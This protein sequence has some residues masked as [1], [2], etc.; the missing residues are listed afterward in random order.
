M[1]ILA[2]EA[3][4]Q[5]AVR[6]V[7]GEK[8]TRPWGAWEV[9][10]TGR[11]YILKRI[12]VLPGQR[13]SLQYHHH[14]AEQWTMVEGSAEVEIDGAVR[15]VAAG[16]HVYIPLGATHRIRNVGVEPLVFI[17]VQVGDILDEND[18]VRLEDDY[19]RH[20]AAISAA[21]V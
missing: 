15:A 4:V 17:E 12:M 14:R 7:V 11:G 9:L 1:T 5:P 21:S 10:A 3:D 13:L 8:G 2:A 6:Y 20:P 18:I 16:E 19:G